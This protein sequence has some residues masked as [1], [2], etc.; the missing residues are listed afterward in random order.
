M[1]DEETIKALHATPA[2]PRRQL[3]RP[4]ALLGWFSNVMTPADEEKIS[5]PRRQYDALMAAANEATIAWACCASLHREYAKKDK[6]PFYTT[7]QAHFTDLE[8]MAK[9]ALR[10]AGIQKEGEGK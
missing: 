9:A 10:A 5:I 6:D 3:V 2:A 7:R 1:S 4:S 8:K